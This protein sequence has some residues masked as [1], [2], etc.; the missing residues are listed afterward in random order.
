MKNADELIEVISRKLKENRTVLARSLRYG[1]LTWR[2]T[3]EGQFEIQ[4]EPK[5]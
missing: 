4:L 5:L 3:K 1:R 2:T